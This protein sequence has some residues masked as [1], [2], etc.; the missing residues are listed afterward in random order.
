M[1]IGICKGDCRVNVILTCYREFLVTNK[2]KIF[3]NF[4]SVL[5]IKLCLKI[6]LNRH[7]CTF[8]KQ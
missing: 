1:A 7:L 2:I 6:F 5:Y 4:F 3:S 8:D